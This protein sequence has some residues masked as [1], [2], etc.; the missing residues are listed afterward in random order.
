MN[1]NA[2]KN[3]T[4]YV[5]VVL[6]VLGLLGTIVTI[7]VVTSMAFWFVVLGFVVLAAGNLV[8]GL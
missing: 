6:A 1:L 2:P 5:A 7:P 3:T 4:F 8:S